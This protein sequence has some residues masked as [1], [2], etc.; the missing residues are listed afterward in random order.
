MHITIYAALQQQKK[1][2]K[3]R[4]QIAAKGIIIGK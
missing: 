3:E 2:S 1:G 4:K